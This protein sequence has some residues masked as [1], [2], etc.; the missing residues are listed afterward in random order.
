MSLNWPK[1]NHNHASEY[2]VSGWP[3]VTSSA[4]NEVAGTPISVQFPFVTSWVEIFNTDGAVGDTL[5]VGFTQNGVNSN[6]SANYLVL[7]GGQ[8]TG[9]LELRCKEIWFLKHGANPTSFSVVAGLTNV[10]GSEFPAITGSNGFS[11]VG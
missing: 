1:P 2:Q 9:K 6:P 3:F 10:D 5:R 7:S 8:G 11:G 4:A